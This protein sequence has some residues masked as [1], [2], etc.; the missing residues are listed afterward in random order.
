MILAQNEYFMIT[1]RDDKLFIQVFKPGYS[2]KDFQEIMEKYPRIMITKFMVLREALECA[3]GQA[4]EFGIQKP[5]LE[6]R[7]APDNLEAKMIINL[8]KETFEKTKETVREEILQLLKDHLIVHGILYDVI[9]KELR[10]QKE[11]VVARGTLP[12]QGKDASI[13]YLELPEMK[14]AINDDGS[15]NY[16][17]MNL[18]RYVHK[19]DWVGE[20]ILVKTGDPGMNIKGE[21]LP[22]KEGKDKALRFDQNS[23]D[24]V[25]KENKILLIAKVD[26]ALQIKG[27]KIC[28]INH[29]MIN[30]N[31]GYE[32]GNID[33]DGYITIQGTVE[34]GFSVTARDDISIL[35]EMG[36]GA[37]GKV[38]SKAGNI[39]IKGGISGK[40]RSVLEAGK[41]VFVKY[42]NACTIRAKDSINIG[43]Y[44]LDSDLE[45]DVI[46]VQA[47]NARTIGGSVKAKSKVSLRMVGNV[48]EKETYINVQGFD[49][50]A[51]KKELDAL[52]VAYKELLI[53][54]EKNEREL[55]VYETTLLQFGRIKSD[56]DYIS[57]QRVYQTLID[58]LY[59]LEEQRQELLRTLSS[60]GEGEV[61]IYEKAYPRTFLQ[62]KN[63]QK[64]IKEM[65]TGTFYAQDNQLM[66]D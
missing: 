64:R 32:T 30:G 15:A 17:E 57:Y 51:I 42:T 55:K 47:K 23:I 58:K 14:P 18:F 49:R 13:T 52:L 25:E 28:V 60:R 62:I 50:K 7:I 29:L 12:A 11:I 38:F 19:G 37:V 45:A 20:K 6:L 22:G 41:S 56:D 8:D 39:Y 31:V 44:A 40:G 48:Y 35:G 61:T 34:D 66:F 9:N 27:G 43:Y 5:K 21:E 54:A 33:F 4:I 2:I 10:V 46:L 65:T 1:E 26:G 63:L 3:V 36:M 16:Y 53:K 59:A 24:T